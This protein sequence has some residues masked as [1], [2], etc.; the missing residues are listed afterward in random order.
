MHGPIE[1]ILV[2]IDG[3]EES[4]TAA[5]YA[6]L[7]SQSTGATLMAIYIVNTRAL[8]DLVKT[9]IFLKEEQEE[10]RMDIEA[11]ADRYLNHVKDI[12]QKKGV[13]ITTVKKSGNIHQEIKTIVEEHN[14]DLL[15]IGE[16]SQIKSRRD[17]FYNESERAMRRVRC[18]VLVVKDE[19]RVWDLYE[20]S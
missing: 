12:A 6:V 18:S 2:Y 7:L 10:Y 14:I 8:N 1:R 4:I 11:D 16:L 17:E 5:Q 3:T 15:V 19:D 20:T 9:R 13:A